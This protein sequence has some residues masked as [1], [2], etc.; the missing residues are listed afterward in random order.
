MT[1]CTQKSFQFAAH[2]SRQ[3]VAEF[4]AERLTTD[5]GVL[6]LRQ[7]DR[8]IQLLSRLASCFV[9]QRDPLRVEHTVAEMVAQRVYGLALGYEDL[10]DHEQ[11]RHDPLLGLLAGK[12]DLD[13][14]LAGK[15]TLNRMELSGQDPASSRYHKIGYVEE[16]IDGLLVDLFLEAHEEAPLRIV[17]DLD[18]TDV[19]L[20]GHQEA[21][22]FHGY[23][24][25]YCYLP[26]Y[27]FAGD[28]LLGARLRPADQD[29][30]TGAV[31]ELRRIVAQI[32]QRW[33]Q[34]EIVVRADSGFCREEL[35]G[36]C[37]QQ[38]V[39]YVLGLARNQRLLHYIGPE[40]RQAQ[41]QCKKTGKPARVFAAFDYRTHKSWSRS[42]RVI[43]KAESIPD[44]DNPRFVVT[45]LRA[46]EPRSLYEDLY[47]ARGEMENRIKEQLCLFSDRLS[48]ETMRANQLRLYFSAMAY[49]LLEALRR[50]ALHG[51]EWAQAQVDTLRLRLLKIA[52][53]VQI[54]ARRICLRYTGAY[55]WKLL[56]A[57]AWTALRC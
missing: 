21:R 40:M 50:L 56:F 18:S 14:D 57:H 41:Q 16:K 8:R 28:H 24:D 38:H 17:L 26:L 49:T 47:C 55:P 48:T 25:S 20:H 5:G 52:A 22:F 39:E 30:A 42:R 23:Y 15:S 35:M 33:P 3:V 36:W 1:E 4:S 32:R 2:F 19:P 53:H 9:D 29:G 13:A 10:N 46:G 34:I 37:E 51:T 54:S 7:V 31:D 6:L 43:A 27:I 44:K 12:R 45:S 11:L